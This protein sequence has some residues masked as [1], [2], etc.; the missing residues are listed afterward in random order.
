[1]DLNLRRLRVVSP[2]ESLVYLLQRIQEIG[3]M[4]SVHSSPSSDTEDLSHTVHR[5]RIDSAHTENRHGLTRRERE[6]VCHLARGES[7]KD[8]ARSLGLAPKSI[9]SHK[10]NIMKKLQIHDRVELALFALRHGLASS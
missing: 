5:F 4:S 8:V 2:A 3:H 9:E 6:I 1:M 10:Y 7:V